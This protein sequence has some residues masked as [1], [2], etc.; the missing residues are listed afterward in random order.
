LDLAQT[1]QTQRAHQDPVELLDMGLLLEEVL[2]GLRGQI[3]DQQALV[4]VEVTQAPG[5]Y[6]SRANLRSVVHN[7]VSN[8][9]KF[10]HPARPLRLRLRTY[11]TPQGHPAL[12]VADNGLGM[13]LQ[14]PFNPV[15]QLFSRQ[16]P[17]IEGTGVGLYLVQRIV[18]SNGGQVTVTS[19]LQEGTTFTIHWKN[20]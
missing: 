15:F 3:I 7:L 10:A 17:A 6:Y 11:L 16:H 8:A 4:E 9:L 12:E 19:T 14:D 20:S 18:R 13:N 5:L 1:V 2:L